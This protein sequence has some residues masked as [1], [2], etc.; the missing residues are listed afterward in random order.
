MR[1]HIRDALDRGVRGAAD[2]P[3]ARVRAGKWVAS[4]NGVRWVVEAH[5]EPAYGA[6][7]F[8]VE[9]GVVVP[10][11]AA[12]I[13]AGQDER[14]VSGDAGS[15]AEQRRPLTL[16][17]LPGSGMGLANRLWWQVREQPV[18]ELAARITGWLAGGPLRSLLTMMSTPAGVAEF[19]ERRPAVARRGVLY[20]EPDEQSL[21][22]LAAT[23]AVLGDRDGALAAMARYR[24]AVAGT[25]VLVE[26]AGEIAAR[27]AALRP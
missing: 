1:A 26:R 20:P 5:S 24:A 15:L 25:K 9:W 4:G 17:L 12:L 16:L 23:R 2:L 3:F 19:L 7:V 18:D 22:V 11:A 27:I 13:G 14:I 21:P 8:R 6:G 10:G